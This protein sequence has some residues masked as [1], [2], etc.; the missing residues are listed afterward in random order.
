[1]IDMLVLRCPFQCHFIDQNSN[2]TAVWPSY[3]LA[4]LSI[5]LVQ[6]IDAE[7]NIDNLRH[8]WESLPSSFESMAFKVF[9]HRYDSLDCFYIEIKASPAKLMLGHN[10][11]GSS[12]I[13]DCSMTML[14]LLCSTY[15]QITELLDH[16]LWELAQI[17]ITYSAKAKDNH[18]AKLFINS[19]H[20]VSFGQ[21]KSRTGY[22]G[23]AYFGKKNSRLKKIKVYSKHPEV[24]ET[25]KK[26]KIKLDGELINEVYTPELLTYASGLIRWEC[27]F[28]HRY[29]SR[30][31]ISTFL[32]DIFHQSTFNA[33]A[34]QNY[35]YLGTADL[36]KS[37][38]GQ[39]MKTLNT[40]EVKTQLRALYSK[41]SL[42]TGLVSTVLA[43]SAFR[44]YNDLLRDGFIIARESMSRANFNKHIVMLCACGLSR[45]ALQN[46]NGL[47]NGATI[48]PYVR[49][50][51]IDFENQYPVDYVQPLAKHIRSIPPLRLIA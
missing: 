21:T 51:T 37:L 8:P 12:D 4:S 34:L 33:Q 50:I 31:G 11:F 3:S 40:L 32:K 16:T 23:T 9:D 15:P 28:Y 38:N 14:E 49:F 17:D 36:F 48:I 20:S 10:I 22:D 18:E 47:E 7:G 44:T 24:L 42:K 39:T 29:F 19:L 45:A 46:L 30:L 5:P 13:Y 35:W 26:N 6:S 27:S 1:M 43:D 2:P 41:T 25:I